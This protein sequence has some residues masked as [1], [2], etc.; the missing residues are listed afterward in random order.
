MEI[1]CA[2][3]SKTKSNMVIWFRV[4]DNAGMEFIA[5]FSTKDGMKKTDFN[6]EVFSEE[7]INKNILILKAFKKAR[8]SGVYSCASINGNALVFGEVTRL[9]GPGE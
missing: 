9:A 7:Q 3:V 2:P 1:T 5:S 6:N 8:D 4:Q